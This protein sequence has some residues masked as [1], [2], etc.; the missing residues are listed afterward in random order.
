MEFFSPLSAGSPLAS[1]FSRGGGRPFYILIQHALARFFPA[2]AMLFMV[3]VCCGRPLLAEEALPPELQN[4]GIT[5]HFGQSIP[6]DLEFTDE[7]GKTV[8]LAQYF[9]QDK[10]VLVTLVYYSCPMLCTLVLNGVNDTLHKLDWIPGKQFS[11]LTISFDPTET[12]GL[13]YKQTRVLSRGSKPP[14]SRP[15]LAFFCRQGSQYQGAGR[16]PRLQLSL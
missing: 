2:L 6:L 14:R 16:G 10:P 11:V 15:R 1:G 13:A 4:V 3:L 5:P 12:S 7:N 9:N 8:K